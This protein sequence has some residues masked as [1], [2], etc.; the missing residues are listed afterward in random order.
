MSMEP[1]T[2]LPRLFLAGFTASLAAVPLMKRLAFKLGMIDLPAH[3]KSH[4]KPVPYLGGGAVFSG[5]AFAALAAFF[6]LAGAGQAALGKASFL[7]TAAL[8]AATVGLVDDK[9]SLRASRKFLGQILAASLF[10]AGGYRLQVLHFPGLDPIPLG[11]LSLPATYLWVLALTNAMNLIDG[12]DGLAGSVSLVMLG[13]L[14]A[15]AAMMGD[16]GIAVVC[17][18]AAGGVLGFL[19][20]NW[21]PASIYLGDAGSTGLGMLTAVCALSLGQG[22]PRLP[23]SAALSV[24]P[25]QPF[26][27]QAAALTLLAAYPVLDTTLSVMRRLL[28]GNPVGRAD[29]GHIHHR[30][31]ARGWQAP[32]ICAAA[33]AFTLMAGGILL[34]CL[35]PA[36]PW[37]L[38]LGLASAVTVSGGLAYCGYGKVMGPRAI[39]RSRPHFS[40]ANHF[41]SMQKT[42][43]TLSQHPLE[44][45]ALIEQVCLEFGVL[46]YSL[47]LYSP[48][49]GRPRYVS[50]WERPRQF[51]AEAS[52]AD[53]RKLF[54]DR[55]GGA[56]SPNRVFWCFGPLG[57]EADIDVEHRVLVHEFMLHAV[58][59]AQDLYAQLEQELMEEFLKDAL[60]RGGPL[61][62]KLGG[63]TRAGQ[64]GA[65]PSSAELK[66]RAFGTP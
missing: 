14:A 44:V 4:L 8:A 26:P 9:V 15:A 2:A 19:V 39:R 51:R 41:I 60:K 33:A 12:V 5:L 50:S 23:W 48:W 21:K 29:R 46:Y 56:D 63:L 28:R 58:R 65:S 3:R 13:L 37:A 32:A 66:N 18:G 40:I 35:K 31:Q 45:L 64:K 22:L 20:F 55:L 47:F 42:K 10:V 36:L 34:L 38:G 53:P 43:V 6:L 11:G 61:R 27:Y 16:W 59:R 49:A 30:L 62:E 25:V 24:A 52:A 17:A 57:Q 54:S 1:L 7:L